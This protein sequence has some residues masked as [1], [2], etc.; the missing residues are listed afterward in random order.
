L[1]FFD[2]IPEKS[3]ESGLEKTAKHLKYRKKDTIPPKP[4]VI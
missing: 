3:D 4:H 2:E 1:S